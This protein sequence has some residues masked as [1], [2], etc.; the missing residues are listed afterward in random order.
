MLNAIFATKLGMTQAWSKE[1]KR[2]A[3]TKCKVGNN[4]IVGQTEAL[5]TDKST[6]IWKKQPQTIL[7]VGY[8]TKKLKNMDKPLRARMQKSGFDFGVRQIKGVKYTAETESPLKIGDSLTLEQVLEVG[9]VVKVQGISKGRGFAGVIKRHG[10]HGGPRTH[11]QSDRERA[12]GSIGAGTT[13]GRVWKGKKMPGHYGVD[14]RTVYGLTVLYIDPKNQEVWLSGPVP[15]FN[16]SSVRIEKV[17]KKS[18]VNLDLDSMGLNTKEEVAPVEEKADI[19]TETKSET[20][21]VQKK[22]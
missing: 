1:G 15:G 9:D 13:P 19:S 6:R 2:L 5:L 12:P 3:V 17:G 14:S 11:G 18:S 22:S 4:P 10:F 21:E 7:E 20:Q 16:S 8:G